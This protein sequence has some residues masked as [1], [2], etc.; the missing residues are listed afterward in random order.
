MSRIDFSHD[1]FLNRVRALIE[2]ENMINHGD[3]VLVGLSGG[4]DSVALL[5]VLLELREEYGIN[6]C[7]AHI[8][9]GLRGETADRDMQF[10]EDLCRKFEIP[11]AVSKENVRKIA[12]REHLSIEEAGRK[13][14][15]AFFKKQ[16]TDKIAVAHTKDD[17]AETVLMN[18]LKGNLPLG[19][20]PCREGIIRPL[21]GVTKEEIYAYLKYLGQDFVTD[22]TNFLKDYTRNKIRLDLIPYLEQHFNTNF[23]NTVYHSSDVLYREQ[24]FLEEK[25]RAIYQQVATEE[26]SAVTLVLDQLLANEDVMVKRTIRYAYYQ[27]C[28]SGEQI[29][30]RQTEQ[31]FRLCIEGKKGKRITLPGGIVALLSGEFLVFK[32]SLQQAFG[33]VLLEAETFVC[34]GETEYHICLSKSKDCDAMFCYPIRVKVGDSVW[35]R[36]RCAGDKL[37]F[38]NISIHKK[39]SDFLIDKKIPLHERDY[40]PLICV[41]DCV[42]VVTGHFYEEVSDCPKEEQYYIIINKINKKESKQ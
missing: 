3:R 27:V 36:Q 24:R 38:E 8:H 30:Y 17:N 29:S 12:N 40:I 35:V 7:C 33:P 2:R 23:T 16:H 22:E 14:R 32:H 20:A 34:F 19:V 1:S 41:N 28:C 42:R 4:A 13:V 21:L 11:I 9:H 18:L 26:D 37:Y 39:L 6:L 5:R 25:A 15:Y 31:V 10:A